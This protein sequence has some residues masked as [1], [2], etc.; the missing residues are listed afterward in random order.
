MLHCCYLVK[1]L[2]RVFASIDFQKKVQFCYFRLQL[3]GFEIIFC[4]L[5]LS[6]GKEGQVLKRV[7]RWANFFKF[8]CYGCKNSIVRFNLKII[9]N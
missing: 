1:M 5:L 7:E 3:L 4:R 9:V 2:K 8:Q 6:D